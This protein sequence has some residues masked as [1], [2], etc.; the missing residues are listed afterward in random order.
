MPI[1]LRRRPSAAGTLAVV[2]VSALLAFASTALAKPKPNL[3]WTSSRSA[4]AGTPIP[5]SWTSSNLGKNFKLV[6]QRPFGTAHA[7][8]TVLSLNG[9]SGSAQLPAQSLGTYRYRLAAVRDNRVLVRGMTTIAVFG[10]VPLSTLLGGSTEDGVYATPENS[11]PYVARWG[12]TGSNTVFKA[13]NNRCRKVHIE[14]VTA[15]HDASVVGTIT[16]VQESREAVSLAEPGDAIGSLDAELVPGQTWAVNASLT[17]NLLYEVYF[18]GYG[19]C[20][21]REPIS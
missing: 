5:I 4:T 12:F 1:Q 19:D 20:D 14:F 2:A 10:R 13:K 3:E 11:F 8:K 15:D 16:V 9:R 17:P 21:S 18:N 6:V 7:F